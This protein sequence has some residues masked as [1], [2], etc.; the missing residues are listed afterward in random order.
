MYL[1]NLILVLFKIVLILFLIF[2]L[3]YIILCDMSVF[4]TLLLTKAAFICIKTV[5]LWKRIT[6]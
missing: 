6:N 2:I 1:Y 4:E 5:I 3:F